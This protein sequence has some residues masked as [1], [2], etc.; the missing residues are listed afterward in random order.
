MTDTDTAAAIEALAFRIRTR[1]QAQRDGSEYPDADILASEF[2]TALRGHGW[3]VTTLAPEQA[4]A[5]GAGL[6]KGDDARAA[7][8]SLRAQ[9]AAAERD[10]PDCGA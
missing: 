9:L 4:H 8:A 7:L 3:R 10:G 6:P 5:K 2:I 1:D